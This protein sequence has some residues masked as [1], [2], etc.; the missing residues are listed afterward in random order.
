MRIASLKISSIH[1][2]QANAEKL[3]AIQGWQICALG[4]LSP[5]LGISFYLRH[6]YLNAS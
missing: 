2:M 1:K 5:H 4:K 6:P 3:F